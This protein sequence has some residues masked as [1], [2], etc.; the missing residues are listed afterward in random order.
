MKAHPQ[1]NPQLSAHNPG[2]HFRL[3]RNSSKVPGD[4]FWKDSP[5]RT[6]ILER[7]C[8]LQPTAQLEAVVGA[9]SVHPIVVVTGDAGVGKSTLVA[10]LV[11]PELTDWSVPEGFAHAIVL[12]NPTTNLRSIA[13]DKKRQLERS[14]AAFTQAVAEFERQVNHRERSLLYFLTLMIWKP[15]EHLL[16]APEIRIVLDGF[17][18]LPDGVRAQLRD[19]L[20]LRP[21]H[22]RLV[23]TSRESTPDNPIGF[24]MTVDRADRTDVANYLES[25]HVPTAWHETILDR[26]DD[27]W[28]IASLLADALYRDPG[29]DLEKLPTNVN[30]AY[31]LLLDQAGAS[32]GWHTRFAPVLGPLA[33]AGS[34]AV[35]PLPL[36]SYASSSLGGPSGGDNVSDAL[37]DLAGLVTRRDIGTPEEHAGL[38]HSTLA[39]YLFSP[40]AAY[41]GFRIDTTPAHKSVIEPRSKCW[42]PWTGHDRDDPLYRYAFIYEPEHLWAHW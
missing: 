33:A 20:A 15:L 28:L 22:L 34:G 8:Y 11:R 14:V 27:N 9:S 10:A 25:R 3:G 42:L 18:Q 39:D 37:R 6:L 32:A 38:F 24:T 17:N 1:L 19:S 29:L 35:L 23:I 40:A 21:S 16:G 7:T 13:V 4:V 26:A 5:G 30:G 31:E 41:A 12:L 2:P 36:L